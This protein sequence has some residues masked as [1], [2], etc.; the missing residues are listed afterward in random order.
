MVSRPELSDHRKKTSQEM[1]RLIEELYPICRSITGNGVRE[2]LKAIGKLVPLD[3]VEV[4]SGTP[5]FDWEV[6]REWNVKDAYIL[7][8]YGKKIVDFKQLNLHLLNYSIP[9]NGKMPLTELKKHL[10]TLPD[11]PDLVPYRTSYYKEAWGFCMTQHQ[12]DSLEEGEYQVVVDSTLEDGHLTYGE[13]HIPGRREEEFLISTHTCHPS[14]CN[15]NLSGIAVA[16]FLAKELA[17]SQPEF[18]YRFLFIPGTIGSITWLSRNESLLGRIIGGLVITLLGDD[19][20]FTYKTSRQGNSPIDRIARYYL[21]S[22][23]EGHSKIRDFIPYG[24]DERQY[25]SPGFNLPVGC[26]TRNSYG[27][28]PEY[29]TSADN[30]QFVK[31]ERLAESLEVIQ[32]LVSILENNHYFINLNPKGEPQLGKRGLYDRLGG[33][34]EGKELQ[35]AILWVL[36]YSDGDHDLLDVAEKSGIDVGVIIHAAR[37]LREKELIKPS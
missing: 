8:P 17:A 9:F 11:K 27:E 34:N 4:P 2:T 5:A 25:C 33:G 32:D 1:Y 23:R 31:P 21:N 13:Y 10:F 28:F 29:H 35:L 6:P 37:L 24:Y 26:L 30:L 20:D 36:N 15:D 3:T 7:D 16:T 14:L 18:S 12:Y 22:Q 19:S